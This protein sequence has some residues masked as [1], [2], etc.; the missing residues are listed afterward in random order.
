[1]ANIDKSTSQV[2]NLLR[3]PLAFLIVAGHANTLKFPLHSIDGAIIEYDYS[4][5]MYP[6]HLISQ[7]LFAPAVPLFFMISGFLFFMGLPQYNWNIYKQKMIR[8]AKTLFLPYMIWN[9]I[10]L[11]PIIAASIVKHKGYDAWYFVQC[12]WFC[13]NQAERI[14]MMALTTPAD[15]P[16]WF[17]RDLIVCMVLSPLV[18]FLIKRTWL[19][20]FVL[21]V[22]FIPWIGDIQ[23]QYPFP[24][25]SIPSFMFFSIGAAVAFYNVDIRK[26]FDRSKLSMFIISLYCIMA[27]SE[28][29]MVDYHISMCDTRLLVVIDQNPVLHGFLTFV[30]CFAFLSLS[31]KIIRKYAALE[32]GGGIFCFRCSLAVTWNL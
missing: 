27:A 10:Y 24:G 5:I 15:P 26:L 17:I 8:R 18:Y 3:L 22:L 21:I 7:I 9:I 20:V 23:V 29:M 4:V 28:L 25:I 13:P 16:L 11:I 30:G 19:L 14:P 32:L 31:Y 2:L 12:M 6:I 1:M